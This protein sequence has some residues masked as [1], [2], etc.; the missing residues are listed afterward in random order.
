[1][2]TVYSRMIELSGQEKHLI[3]NIVRSK[4]RFKKNI[5]NI[6]P[7][8]IKCFTAIHIYGKKSLNFIKEFP[9]ADIIK[10]KRIY[11][12]ANNIYKCIKR[13]LPYSRCLKK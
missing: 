4:N 11:A 6:F 13:F 9:H 12:F 3:E 8:Y 2:N 5:A 7:E 1:M 10:S